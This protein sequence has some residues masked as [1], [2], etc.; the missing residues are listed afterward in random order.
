MVAAA[1]TLAEA[2]TAAGPIAVGPTAVAGRIPEHRGHARRDRRARGA[3]R[4]TAGRIG[5]AGRRRAGIAAIADRRTRAAVES[6]K[7]R[8]PAASRA[9]IASRA[10]RAPLVPIAAAAQRAR[11]NAGRSDAMVTHVVLYRPKANLEKAIRSALM[12][13]VSAARDEIP[14]IRR[15]V[16]G[17]RLGNAPN[18]ALGNFP[19]LPYAAI[20]E[21]SDREGLEAYLAHPG[22]QRLGAL[23]NG[24]VEAGLV[25]DYEMV[26]ATSVASLV[27]D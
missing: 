18:Y 19:D 6:R 5:P 12:E 11:R 1:R 3:R 16:V 13:A 9:G 2:R 24:T 20:L 14:Q 23:F 15:F 21:F 4:T 22:H 8:Q 25:Y 17:R 27:E 26:D 7:D 10:D